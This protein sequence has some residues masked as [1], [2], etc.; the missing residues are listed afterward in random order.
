M[1]GFVIM[2]IITVAFGALLFYS[3]FKSVDDNSRKLTPEN[4]K[5]LFGEK[6][7][8]IF[9]EKISRRVPITDRTLDVFKNTD[10]FY[11]LS[12]CYG[13][14]LTHMV[15]SLEA[16][17]FHVANVFLHDNNVIAVFL[18]DSDLLQFVEL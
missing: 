6:Y 10:G 12:R 4:L 14:T 17:S 5:K 11:A 18:T 15:Y 13:L 3:M 8:P 2:T 1:T 7:I 9:P 16:D